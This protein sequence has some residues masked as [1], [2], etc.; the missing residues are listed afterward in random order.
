MT[1]AG[2]MLTLCATD[3]VSEDAPLRVE[4][5]GMDYAVYTREG[6]FYVTADL[7]T[8]GP[9]Y[10]SDGYQEGEEIECPFHQGRFSFITGEPVMPPCTE[11]LRTW[12]AHLV[13]GKVCIDPSEVRTP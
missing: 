9:G 5:G 3:E 6:S 1:E 4:Q 2:E 12:T 7:C 11:A 13:D 10:M 8:H